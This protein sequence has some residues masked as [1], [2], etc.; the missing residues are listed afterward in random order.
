MNIQKSLGTPNQDKSPPLEVK[1]KRNSSVESI[2]RVHA[3]VCDAKGRILM[4]AGNANFETFIRSALK[5]FQALPFISSGTADKINCRE[6]GLAIS[7]GS[8]SASVSHAREAFKILW[9]ANIEVEFLQC[10]IPIN[11]KSP[12]EHN[13]SGKHAAF[14]ATSKRMGWS[15]NNYLDGKHPLQK[16]VFR[17][18]AKI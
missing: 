9:N 13:C 4:R 10:P 12:L 16:E 6:Q 15:L 5:P 1:L 11:R 7:C 3:V 2:H 18:V 17:R 8:H 14:L